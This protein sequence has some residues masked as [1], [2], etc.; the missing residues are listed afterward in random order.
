M[1]LGDM[2][3]EDMGLPLRLRVAQA[4]DGDKPGAWL[5]I[6]AIPIKSRRS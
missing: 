6:A 5:E 4:T 2:G 1:E 3:L